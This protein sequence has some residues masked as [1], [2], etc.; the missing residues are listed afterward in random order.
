MHI[1][2]FQQLPKTNCYYIIRKRHMHQSTNKILFVILQR[3]NSSLQHHIENSFCLP[4]E[5]QLYFIPVFVY[6]YIKV[7]LKKGKKEMASTKPNY[8]CQLFLLAAITS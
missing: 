8:T 7:K 5:K 4:K 2:H 6:T 1:T 3:C